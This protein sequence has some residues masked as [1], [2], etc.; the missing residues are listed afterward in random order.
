MDE[1]RVDNLF[2]MW[3]DVSENWVFGPEK[4]AELN[5]IENLISQELHGL[6]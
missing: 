4:N 6:K 2:R 5:R 1:D 3:K